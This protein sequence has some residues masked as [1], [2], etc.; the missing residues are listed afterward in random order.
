MS[1]LR[2]QFTS[3]FVPTIAP[4]RECSYNDFK[5]ILHRHREPGKSNYILPDNIEDI[6]KIARVHIESLKKKISPD[7]L[8]SLFHR[9]HRE[10]TRFGIASETSDVLFFLILN[11][12]LKQGMLTRE[13]LEQFKLDNSHLMDP[14]SERNF[15]Q[16]KLAAEEVFTNT[17]IGTML[18][19][20]PQ[21]VYGLTDEKETMKNFLVLFLTNYMIRPHRFPTEPTM[22]F[23]KEGVISTWLQKELEELEFKTKI[24]YKGDWLDLNEQKRKVQYLAR[25]SSEKI[26]VSEDFNYLDFAKFNYIKC[27]ARTEFIYFHPGITYSDMKGV[28][29]PCE[30]LVEA[31][32]F[33]K[34]SAI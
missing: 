16:I 5:T 29:K 26:S 25:S 14:P 31:D 22:D 4:C 20:F 27:F 33:L 28:T 23:L 34:L 17:D 13:K 19:Y 30:L 8:E 9:V 6:P 1:Q 10:S 11:T 24:T 18:S 15:D 21:T 7:Q 3:F 12:A 32:M 2:L